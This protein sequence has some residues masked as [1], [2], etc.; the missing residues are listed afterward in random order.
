MRKTFTFI[1][2]LL[3]STAMYAQAPVAVGQS[4]FN[5]GIGLSSWGGAS[6]RGL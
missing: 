6:L 2:A 5:A 3:A 1:T 4:Q